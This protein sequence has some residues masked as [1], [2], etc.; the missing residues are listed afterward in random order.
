MPV[1]AERRIAAANEESRSL[2]AEAEQPLRDVEL[3][4]AV[5]P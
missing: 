5:L 4:A 3:D 1:T 2:A